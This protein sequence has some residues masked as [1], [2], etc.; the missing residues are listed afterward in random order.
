MKTG[1]VKYKKN[2]PVLTRLM[3]T[4]KYFVLL[5]VRKEDSPENIAHGLAMGIFVGFLPIIP[6]Q[7]VFILLLCTIFK[8]NKLA[9]VIGST[10]LTN[11][12]SAM[13]V[14]YAQHFLGRIFILHEFSYDKF[15]HLFF[16]FS[17]SEINE[18][19]KEILIMIKMVSIGGVILGVLFYPF[20]YYFT[21]NYIIKLR[22]KIKDR[23]LKK[24]FFVNK[25]T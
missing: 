2:H 10:A 20:A 16:H 3:R 22:K 25:L 6:L 18:V 21:K 7:T 23:K 12:F 19:G 11:P 13:P 8:T 5:F 1:I 4:V 9:G 14:F 24:R 17:I 15:K